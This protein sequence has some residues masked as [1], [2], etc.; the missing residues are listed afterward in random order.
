[1]TRFI[2]LLTALL[3]RAD[4]QTLDAQTQS[5][6]THNQRIVSVAPSFT[7][8]LY[9][10]G[11]GSQVVGNTNYC[12]YPEEAKRTQKIGDMLN[13][14]LERII[15]LR[16]DLV[17]C[18][19]W[20]WHVPESLRKMGIRVVEIRDAQTVEDIYNRILLIGETAG[21]QTEAMA[22][23][24]RMK[25]DIDEIRRSVGVSPARARKVYVELDSGQWT[26]GSGSYMNQILEIIGAEN[27]FRDRNEAYF[28]A[29]AESIAS[30]DP[31]LII[32]LWRKSEDYRN[33]ESWQAVRAVRN[34]KILDVN[35]MDWNLITR[36]SPRLVQGIRQ[37]KQL[38]EDQDENR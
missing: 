16:P 10:L 1:M 31:D 18:G 12:D 19:T 22:V 25:S 17:Y 11:L 13:P 24:N 30:R 8:I 6:Q 27:I 15:A 33:A 32:S 3:L 2:L 23:V 34:G 7:E 21:K 26:V 14:N 20:K 29:T 38:I 35:S 37:L 9:A 36:Q 28:M 5:A 4:A